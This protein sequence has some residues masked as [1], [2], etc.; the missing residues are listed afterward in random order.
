MERHDKIAAKRRAH[1]DAAKRP[2]T[3]SRSAYRRFGTLASALPQTPVVFVG[4]I[5]GM[6]NGPMW[7]YT[8]FGTP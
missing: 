2:E 5:L 8:S 6:A 3:P 4:W 1:N 7:A